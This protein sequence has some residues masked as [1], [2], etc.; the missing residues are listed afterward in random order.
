MRPTGERLYGSESKETSQPSG[1]AVGGATGPSFAAGASAEVAAPI[2]APW[3]PGAPG[4]SVPASG[5][6]ALPVPIQGVPGPGIPVPGPPAPGVPGLGAPVQ[7]V[8]APS[9]PLPVPPAQPDPTSPTSPASSS[10]AARLYGEP[11]AIASAGDLDL[12][13]P[14]SAEPWVPPTPWLPGSDDVSLALSADPGAD[15]RLDSRLATMVGAS[16]P[17]PPGP[18]Q[19]GNP[20]AARDWASA[21]QVQ[22]PQPPRRP[23][24]WWRQPVGVD[25]LP[26]GVVRDLVAGLLGA[27][28]LAVFSLPDPSTALAVTFA[29]VGLAL[30][31]VLGVRRGVVALAAYSG[32]ALG[33][34]K[35]L[36]GKLAASIHDPT[37]AFVLEIAVL[38]LFAGGIAR[39]GGLRRRPVLGFAVG[40]AGYIAAQ[41]AA[42]AWLAGR[43]GTGFLAAWRAGTDG[44]L[45]YRDAGIA[46]VCAV[47]VGFLALIGST[48]E[49]VG[50]DGPYRATGDHR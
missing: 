1:S 15:G 27:G 18:P 45:I 11:T 37:L 7:G 14:P 19:L 25:R 5:V 31:F 9:L 35:V 48:Q 6:P 24:P 40:F 29:A 10:S 44:L 50:V 34:V 41:A 26:G 17:S 8:P 12:A 4:P 33:G 20:F 3:Q 13:E 30:G 38:L 49:A 22:P 16:S 39:V 2:P 43:S 42:V 47:A 23:A 46:A 28:L 21:P 32:A 36:P